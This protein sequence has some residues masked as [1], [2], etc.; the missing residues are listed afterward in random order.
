MNTHR[1]A[2]LLGASLLALAVGC[3]GS[4]KDDDD[5]DDLS[6]SGDE[7]GDG[8]TN[9][10]EEAAGSDPL[11]AEDIPYEGGW[12]KSRCP[13]DLVPTGDEPGQIAADF[14]LQDQY[15]QDWSLH[16][17]CGETVMLEFSGFT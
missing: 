16:D 13:D 4:D 12:V 10:D 17:F 3:A 9:G 1:A 7:D 6:P 2:A 15:G 14:V 11:D 5:D 8:Y